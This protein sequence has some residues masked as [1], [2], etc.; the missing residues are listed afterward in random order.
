MEWFYTEGG[1]SRGPVSPEQFQQLVAQGT[2][3]AQTLVWRQGM[4]NWQTYASHGGPPAQA[5]TVPPPPASP[6]PAGH[7]SCAGCGGTFPDSEVI[8]LAGRPYCATCKPLAIQRLKEGV[9]TNTAFD[10]IRN[11]HLKHEA[12]VKSV[13][14]LYYIG[15]I[16]FLLG[17]AGGVII[18][19]SSNSNGAEALGR[20]VGSTTVFVILGIGLL[21]VGYGLRGLKRWARIPCGILSGIGLIGFPVGTLINAYILYL[22]FSKKGKM[23]FSDE[24]K[25]V[26]AQTP[27]IKYR[28]SIVVWILVGLL[29]VLC[30]FGLVAGFLGRHR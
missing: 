21:Y 30:G 3:T 5:P 6:L 10:D 22:I 26:M 12:S 18:S 14:F 25:D 17:G 27:H 13:G 15:G 8:P 20:A 29:V 9:S 16:A 23:V 11:E 7:V 24:Y 28:T 19:L 4:E 1:E 2:I